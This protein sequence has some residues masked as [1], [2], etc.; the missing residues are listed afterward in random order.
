MNT[1]DVLKNLF[2]D[3]DDHI[4]CIISSR[5]SEKPEILKRKL[6]GTGKKKQSVYKLRK[7]IYPAKNKGQIVRKVTDMESIVKHF[8][9]GLPG[10]FPMSHGSKGGELR[11]FGNLDHSMG[12][13]NVAKNQDSLTSYD[14]DVLII[15]C[16]EQR[17]V[18]PDDSKDNTNSE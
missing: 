17:I 5:K 16:T 2:Q 3:S 9:R 11:M 13:D 14:G 1:F 8:S 6:V 7:G 12:W 18:A 15:S 4:T 10:N